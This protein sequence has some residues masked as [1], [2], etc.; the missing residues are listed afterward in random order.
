MRAESAPFSPLTLLV[1]LN[2]GRVGPVPVLYAAVVD[3][4]VALLHPRDVDR[5]H[6]AARRVGRYNLVP[7]PT[8]ATFI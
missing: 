1:E 3:A 8:H 2:E 6:L 4:Q 7:G 5:T